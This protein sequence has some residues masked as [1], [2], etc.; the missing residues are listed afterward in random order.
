MKNASRRW[1]RNAS[2]TPISPIAWSMQASHWHAG[3]FVH[4]L[5]GFRVQGQ[6]FKAAQVGRHDTRPTKAG[7]VTGKKA[8]L[9]TQFFG[10]GVHVVHELVDERNGD[11]LYLR[12]GVGHF[13]HQNVAATVNAAF[14]FG[15]EHGLVCFSKN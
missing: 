8:A 1:L 4:L 14:G 5:D 10:F 7:V 9:A 12:F 15:V 2:G 3:V 11:L 13:P 6:H